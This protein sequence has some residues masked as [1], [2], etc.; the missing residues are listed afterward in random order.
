[1]LKSKNLKK[2][3]FKLASGIYCDLSTREVIIFAL[4]YAV[5]LNMKTPGVWN[6]V[7]VTGGE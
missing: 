4:E 5:I 7:I 2:K 1:M 6:D 3:Y